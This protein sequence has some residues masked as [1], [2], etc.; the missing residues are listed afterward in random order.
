MKL[1]YQFKLLPTF[2]Q[3]CRMSKWLD[4]LR[5]QYNYLLA[6]RFDWWEM[7]RC[8]VNA[9]PL[10]CSSAEPREQPEYYGQKRSL[11]NLKAEREW[12]KDIHA[13][14]LQEMV[15]R[16]DLAFA[17]FIKGDSNGKR[18]G[19]PRFKGKNRYRTFAYQRV[20]SDCIQGNLIELPKLGKIKFIQHRPIPN[21]F[22]IKRA[23]VTYKAD[24][25]YVTLTLEDVSVPD[26]P[27]INIEPTETNSIGVDAG[28]EY[29]AACS[30]GTM[31][32][33]PKFYRRTEQK[34]AK[35]QAKRELRKK[36]STARRML[37]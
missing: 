12:Y 15:K 7:N 35:L 26:N 3:Q 9:C 14:I 23:L 16:V 33:P 27:V 24:G 22:V 11:V 8:P 17:R 20:K 25:W 37:G 5:H 18:S 19:K 32:E 28:L 30:D 13:D 31:V 10:L 4:M 36:G 21:G 29:F 6:D 34:L 1:A 2:D